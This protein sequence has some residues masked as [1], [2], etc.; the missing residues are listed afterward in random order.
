MLL[1]FSNVSF[2]VANVSFYF[3]FLPNR[4]YISSPINLTYSF[5]LSTNHF[6]TIFFAL[7]RLHCPSYI[8]FHAPFSSMSYFVSDECIVPRIFTSPL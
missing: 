6:H 3:F 5:R 1:Q 2:V 7:F 4:S 8:M